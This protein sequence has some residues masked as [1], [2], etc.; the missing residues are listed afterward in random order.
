MS[1]PR[2]AFIFALACALAWAAGMVDAAAT[3]LR[4]VSAGAVRSVLRAMSDDY[5]RQT[6]HT[7]RF[8]FSSTGELRRIIAAGEPA[9]LVI[10]AAA[11]MSELERSGRLV[12]GSRVDIGR[13]GMGVVVRDGT[14]VPDVSSADA[15]KRV[16]VAAGSISYTDPK[17]GG[18]SY[19]HLMKIAERFGIAEAVKAKGVHAT[20]GDDAAAK[21]ASG[22][23]D[24]AVV[25]VSEINAKGAVLAGLLPEALQSWSVYAAAVPTT[26][27]QPQLAKDLIAALMGPAMR[28]QWSAAG[29]QPAQ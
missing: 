6:G 10:T 24:V 27:S 18:A 20:G 1:L 11:V 7:L 25:L 3:E 8:V 23:A 2:P 14:P 19:V 28:G 22:Q 26:S 4:I 17:L 9:D 29:W 21:V 12:A 13:V 5:A 16:L 15:V